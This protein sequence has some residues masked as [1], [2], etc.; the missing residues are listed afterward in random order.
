MRKPLL[1][2][3]VAAVLLLPG[4]VAADLTVAV[5]A[6]LQFAF[7]EI[8]K[9]FAKETGI[10]VKPVYGASGK[11]QSQIRAGAPFDV[12]VS[13]DVDWVDSLVK[14]KHAVGKPEIYAYGKLLLWT[15]SDVP[16][17][18]G[19]SCLLDPSVRKVAVGDLK[20]TI[21]G[22][23]AWRVL[24]KSGLLEQVKP[25]VVY[26]ANIGQVAQYISSGAT[27]AG[28]VGKGQ[29][30]AGPLAGK[31]K[32]F[33]IPEEETGKMPQSMAMTRYGADN[34]PKSARRLMDFL[35]SEKARQIL[36][37]FGYGLP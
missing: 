22:P 32:W 21:Y 13:A 31:G 6:N 5:A 33:E 30:V 16:V 35:L 14:G 10:E 19:L 9:D 7:E 4:L 23:A 34:N 11:L 37:K 1:P 20:L 25:K 26:G 17:E 2:L 8:R 29:I 27:Q 24:E 3:L 36:T 12:F 28:F 18:K 15:T